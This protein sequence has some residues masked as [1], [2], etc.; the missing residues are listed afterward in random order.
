LNDM[1]EHIIFH[2][3]GHISNLSAL[4]TLPLARLKASS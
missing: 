3:S 2:M 4:R 1:F